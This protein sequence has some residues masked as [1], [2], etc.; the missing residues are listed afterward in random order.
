MLLKLTKKLNNHCGQKD[1]DYLDNSNITENLLGVEK[2][3]LNRK[4]TVFTKNLL[5]YLN[6][7]WLS[8]DTTGHDSI[9]K[10]SKYSAKDNTA[11]EVKFQK[12]QSKIS[13]NFDLLFNN[14]ANDEKQTNTLKNI[15]IKDLQK[16][17]LSHI[18]MNSIRNKLDSFFEFTY[19]L[20]DFLAVIETKLDSSLPTG[21]FNP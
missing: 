5:Q 2:L 14:N 3:H 20:A 13:I 18:N 6:N 1:I 8:S 21:Q 11:E 15:R 9:P 4:V 17:F 12:N 7:V 10:I 19:D 16:V